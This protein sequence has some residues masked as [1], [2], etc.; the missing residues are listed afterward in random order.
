[1][2][3]HQTPPA[4][5]VPSGQQESNSATVVA[6]APTKPEPMQTNEPILNTASEPQRVNTMQQLEEE[7]REKMQYVELSSHDKLV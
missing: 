3:R 2:N 1:M 5:P 7:E 6:Q 4:T